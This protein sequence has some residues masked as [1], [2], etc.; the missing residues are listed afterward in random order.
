MSLRTIRLAGGLLVAGLILGF[1]PTA[2]AFADGMFVPPPRHHVRH[3]VHYA[4]RVIEHVRVVNRYVDRP[5][6]VYVQSAC[7]G[8]GG[9]VNYVAPVHYNYGTSCGGCGHGFGTYYN[10]GGYV[11]GRAYIGDEEY[12]PTYGGGYGYNGGYGYTG[13]YGYPGGYIGS[14]YLR[15][16]LRFAGRTI[17]REAGF[18]GG[19]YGRGGFGGRRFR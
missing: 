11:A 1:A 12:G 17:A 19:F 7:G 10:A 6:P 15:G 9:H 16:G 5:V 3:H 8:C 2:P 18:R 14:G 4:P 13:G